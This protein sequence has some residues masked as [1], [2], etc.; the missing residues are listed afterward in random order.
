MKTVRFAAAAAATVGALTLT[1]VGVGA[2]TNAG[3]AVGATGPTVVHEPAFLGTRADVQAVTTGNGTTI[4]TLRLADL[5]L[6]VRGT[7]LGAHVHTKPCGVDPAASGP[8]HANASAPAGTALRDREIWLDVDVNP[9]GNARSIA[10]A[11]WVIEPGA[12][13]SVVVHALPTNPQTGGA[14]ARVLCTDV[15]FGGAS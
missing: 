3:S 9:A 8:H 7:S 14:G 6:A 2:T 11:D 5:P 13:R 15:P 1:A 10:T 12:A 4:V